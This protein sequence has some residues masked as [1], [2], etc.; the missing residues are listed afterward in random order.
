MRLMN[1]FYGVSVHMGH[2]HRKHSNHDDLESSQD[3]VIDQ[4][5]GNT[6]VQEEESSEISQFIEISYT[7]LQ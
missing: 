7:I 5:D 3:D 6:E 2:T 1:I 4:I